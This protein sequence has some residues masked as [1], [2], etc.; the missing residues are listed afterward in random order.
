VPRDKDTGLFRPFNINDTE[1]HTWFERDRAHVELRNANTDKTILEFW[2]E[3]VS[4]AYEDGFLTAHGKA[5]HVEMYNLALDRGLL[6][7]QARKA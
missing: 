6:S 7:K 3:A 5:L 4:E 2:D 1:L